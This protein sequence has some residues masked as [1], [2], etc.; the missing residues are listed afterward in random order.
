MRGGSELPD[1]LTFHNQ[2]RVSLTFYTTMGVT[3]SSHHFPQSLQDPPPLSTNLY[4]PFPK[5]KRCSR[6]AVVMQLTG[7]GLTSSNPQRYMNELINSVRYHYQHQCLFAAQDDSVLIYGEKNIFC[8]HWLATNKNDWPRVDKILGN[9]VIILTTVSDTLSFGL[10]HPIRVESFQSFI[11]HNRADFELAR[12]V[13]LLLNCLSNRLRQTQNIYDYI[14]FFTKIAY[15]ALHLVQLLPCVGR[16]HFFIPF[17][18][19]PFLIFYT[20]L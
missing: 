5:K 18:S 8:I 7:E 10:S 14:F 1:R 11:C 2:S 16:L 6:G 3:C 19:F 12:S 15:T 17:L 20:P 9:P 13:E 4:K